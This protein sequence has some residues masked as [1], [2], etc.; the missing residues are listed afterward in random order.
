MNPDSG[1]G[2]V[3]VDTGGAT[4]IVVIGSGIA[5]IL[6]GIELRSRGLTDGTILEKADTL[7]GT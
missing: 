3:Q 5:G 1:K 2:S 7:G 4:R 6:T